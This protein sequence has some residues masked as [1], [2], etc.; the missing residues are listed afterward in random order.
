MGGY[1]GLDTSNYTT[2]LAWCCEGK[3][4]QKKSPLPVKAGELGLRQSDAVF[5]HVQGL[6]ALMEALFTQSVEL[7]AVGVSTRPRDVEGSYMP[8]FTVG[9]SA[10]RQL[11]A[12][13]ALPLYEFSHQCGHIMAALYSAG[14]LSLRRER[15]LAFHVSGGT[16]EALLVEPDAEKVIRARCI[17]GTLDLNA[18]QAI[19]RVGV[20]LG[21]PF[22][23]GP[24]LEKLAIASEERFSVKPAMKGADCCLSGIENQCK[25]MW[26]RGAAKESVARFCLDAILGTLIQMTQGI[27]EE[28]GTLPLVFSG[29]VMAN[30]ILRAALTGR[31]G[32]HFAA[33][34]F[35]AD[36]AAG[37]A[38]L[39]SLRAQEGG[40]V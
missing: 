25:T 37:I 14:Q 5:H 9:H 18:G 38:V 31:F 27:L 19:D 34:E 22:P 24:M 16:T 30:S 40:E 20:M 28:Y 39:T 1:L 13:L 26:E 35:S 8:C 11:C 2:S 15:F 17:A 12:A 36:N 23:A 6:P 10:A 7:S 29:G 4:I 3:V 32:A 33:P 21:L